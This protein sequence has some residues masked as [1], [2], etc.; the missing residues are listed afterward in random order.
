MNNIV[1][2][3][4]GW[5]YYGGHHHENHFTKFAISYW[6]YEK[7]GIDK[8]LITL[9]AQILS[10][11]V[12]RDEVLEELTKKPYDEGTI[13][14][15]I[16]FVTKKLDLTPEEYDR[17]W[18]EPNKTYEDYPSNSYLFEKVVKWT[19]PFLKLIFLHQPQSVFKAEMRNN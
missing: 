3:N 6:L 13:E 11:E 7:F 17:I 12:S 19:T 16:E 8:R 18:N 1:I 5:E 9:S 2:V 15:T 4:Y 10:G 14:N